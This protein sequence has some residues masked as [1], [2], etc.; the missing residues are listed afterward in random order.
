MILSIIVPV[1]N[2]EKTIIQIL[3]KI[4]K[5]SSNLTEY[6]VVVIDDGSTDETALLING[7]K[8]ERIYLVDP[9]RIGRAAA[10]NLGLQKAKCDYVA[11]LDADDEAYPDRLFK[12]K[13]I[14]D[15]SQVS[16]VASNASIYDDCENSLGQTNFSSDHNSLVRD[17]LQLNI[18][19]GS[20]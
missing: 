13:E 14:L 20:I 15:N 6:E 4:K 5:N 11:I 18:Y 16:L 17:I 10:L 9:G 2:E 3:E 12:Q 19:N 7:F 1:Y 8:D